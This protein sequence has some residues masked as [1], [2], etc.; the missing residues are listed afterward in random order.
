MP[1]SNCQPIRWLDLGL[2]IQIHILNVRQYISRS[3]KDADIV[4]HSE[5]QTVQIQISWL[6]KKPTDLDLQCLQR[7]GISG[8]SRTRVKFPFK[9]FSTPPPTPP[10]PPPPT[11]LHQAW[12]VN[13]LL[14]KWFTWNDKHYFL[15]RTT[16]FWN[17]IVC[18]Y[19]R[20]F[21]GLLCPHNLNVLSLK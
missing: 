20:H 14:N 16:I 21:Y 3:I 10:T 19:N 7:H 9:T 18:C 13:H 4:S 2:L 12:H 1:T 5:W 17:V 6:L 11:P 15:G 8:F